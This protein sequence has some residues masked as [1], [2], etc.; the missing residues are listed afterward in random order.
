MKKYKKKIKHKC[1]LKV[2]LIW[3]HEFK[4]KIKNKF[5][6]KLVLENLS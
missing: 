5:K 2:N 4:F 6:I 1:V 3:K